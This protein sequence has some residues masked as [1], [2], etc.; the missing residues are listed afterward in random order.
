[1]TPHSSIS[2]SR[3]GIMRRKG[4]IRTVD[5]DGGRRAGAELSRCSSD[6]FYSFI[7]NIILDVKK[8][9][10]R[11]FKDLQHAMYFTDLLLRT[12]LCHGLAL[13]HF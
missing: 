5:G 9:R 7:N 1:M 13:P 11:F 12:T 8:K 10:G 4:S 3:Q 6:Y 2:Q